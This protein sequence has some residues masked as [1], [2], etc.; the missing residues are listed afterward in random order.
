VILMDMIMPVMTGFEATRAIRQ[1][2]E[3]R[4]TVIIGVSASVLEADRQ[5]IL[6]A[7]CDAVLPKPVALR[8]LLALLATH[9]NLAWIYAET[10]R[11][12]LKIVEAELVLL[13]QEELAAL[14]KLAKSGR[15]LEIQAH[16]TR[17]AQMDAA[18]LPFSNQLQ[19]LVKGFEIDQIETFV[20]QFIQEE[21]DEPR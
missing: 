16:A 4:A 8:Q 21:P 18:Y 7:G 14:Y 1:L 5:Q 11:P 3:L 20:K 6:N 12:D 19:K 15:I 9:L 2:P 17:L 10:A 13:P